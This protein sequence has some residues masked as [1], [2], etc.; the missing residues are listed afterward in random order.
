MV[1]N[2]DQGWMGLTGQGMVHILM[3]DWPWCE[4]EVGVAIMGR[5][6]IKSICRQDTQWEHTCDSH[7]W[8]ACS[9]E[10]DSRV[11][12]IN[13]D[14]YD[15]D[16]Q[17][18]SST[19]CGANTMERSPGPEWLCRADNGWYTRLTVRTLVTS[20]NMVDGL[21]FVARCNVD[22]LCMAD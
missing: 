21:H 13:R 4:H 7:W 10:Y 3:V 15:T 12:S 9:F 22:K 14:D 19:K 16:R 1:A 11:G 6:R 18:N 20:K 17:F 5:R 8:K 2:V